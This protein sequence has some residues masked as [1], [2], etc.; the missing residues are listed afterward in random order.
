MHRIYT[1]YTH[2]YHPKH[3][4]PQPEALSACGEQFVIDPYSQGAL[5]SVQEVVELFAL[6]TIEELRS[7][8]VDNTQ[9]L[10]ISLYNLQQAYFTSAQVTSDKMHEVCSLTLRHAVDGG[11]VALTEDA[12][13]PGPVPL[14]MYF[15]QRTLAAAERRARLLPDDGVAAMHEALLLYIMKRY[16]EAG[17]SLEAW[18]DRFGGGE[19]GGKIDD[20]ATHL[21]HKCNLMKSFDLQD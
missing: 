2:P 14:C 9:L 8:T 4:P 20:N 15:L 19:Y 1:P 13:R 5:F 18:I 12:C 17:R 3:H 10:C 7:Y 6:S 21:L 11:Y 16:D